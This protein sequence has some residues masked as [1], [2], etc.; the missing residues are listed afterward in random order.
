LPRRLS[1]CGVL[2]SE[3]STGGVRYS[4]CRNACS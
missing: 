3:T 1:A 4:N 2:A